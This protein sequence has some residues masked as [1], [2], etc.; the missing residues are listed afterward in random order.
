M[1]VTIETI[2][3][4]AATLEWKFETNDENPNVITFGFAT[5]NYVDK[6]GDK[7]IF[8]VCRVSEEGDYITVYAPMAENLTKCRFKGAVLAA[9]GEIMLN[10][11]HTQIEYDPK[12]GEIRVAVDIP[13]CDSVI[14]AKQLFRMVD[15][16]I[17]I[18]D[19]YQPVMRHAMETG[20][21]DMLKKWAPPE[22]E[23][24]DESKPEAAKS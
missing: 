2:K 16:I 7:Y 17:C 19:I 18:S 9:A 14:T 21:V 23:K 6:D 12:D 11:R 13:V 10:T 22:N 3:Q 1:P 8:L 24:K 5:Q 20:Q 4:H 15:N